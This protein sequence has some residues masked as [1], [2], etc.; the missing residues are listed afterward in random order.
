MKFRNGFRM[1]PEWFQNGFQCILDGSVLGICTM[2]QVHFGIV[3]VRSDG[4]WRASGGSIQMAF[5][6]SQLGSRRSIAST[7]GSRLPSVPSAEEASIH[8][9][10]SSFEN[11]RESGCSQDAIRLPESGAGHTRRWTPM[12]RVDTRAAGVCAR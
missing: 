12:N 4:V 8:T 7:H 1:V 10:G 9:H 6:E 2:C 3:C 5:G 11:G